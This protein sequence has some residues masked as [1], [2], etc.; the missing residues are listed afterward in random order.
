LC[1]LFMIEFHLSVPPCLRGPFR[2]IVFKTHASS[3][4]GAP[5]PRR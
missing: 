2:I 4:S 5:R 3:S 1:Q